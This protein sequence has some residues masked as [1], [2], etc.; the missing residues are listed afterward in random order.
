MAKTSL[1]K[2][3]N[4]P[5]QII[6]SEYGSVAIGW[7]NIESCAESVLSSIHNELINGNLV[8]AFR[9]TPSMKTDLKQLVI[10]KNIPNS[11]DDVRGSKTFAVGIITSGWTGKLP[12]VGWEYLTDYLS[13]SLVD[14]SI[15][16]DIIEIYKQ[17]IDKFKIE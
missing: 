9:S 17:T 10:V 7:E 13:N 8:F 4:T 6:T 11:E 3:I 12:Y 16:K 2:K 14:W 15:P 5:L 1:K